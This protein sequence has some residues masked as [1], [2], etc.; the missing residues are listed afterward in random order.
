ML[1]V[2]SLFAEKNLEKIADDITK[3]G[4]TLYKIDM[5]SW[6]G[7]D[8]MQA[9]YQGDVD[10]IGGY[11][12]YLDD[13]DK[14]ICIFYSK[15]N[16]HKI[17]FQVTFDSTYKMDRAIASTEV[18]PFNSKELELYNMREKAKEHASADTLFRIYKNTN[19]NLIP[20]IYNGERK[21]YIITGTTEN[22]I[23]PLGN[24]YIISFNKNLDIQKASKIHKSFIPIENAADGQT[25]ITT[26]HSHLNSTGDFI[27]P[28]DICTI[29]EYEKM[30]CLLLF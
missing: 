25:D 27:T 19:Y 16:F 12:S 24:D 22:D 1:P 4:K 28:T 6:Y 26:I 21:V 13:E 11:L 17:I 9:K 8:V 15:D 18:R 2:C 7:T 23:V 10:N 14:R 20:L 29:M 30:N 5:A 3:E